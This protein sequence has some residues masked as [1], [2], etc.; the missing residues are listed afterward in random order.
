[1]EI[2][3][4]KRYW[5]LI[6]L[7]GFF[8]VFAISAVSTFLVTLDRDNNTEDATDNVYTGGSILPQGNVIEPETTVT[9]V[10]PTLTIDDAIILHGIY[11]ENK[12]VYEEPSVTAEEEDEELFDEAVIDEAEEEEEAPAPKTE[13]K[14]E[15]AP[16]TEEKKEEVK[17]EEKK[18][19]PKKEEVKV[20]EPKKEEAP[21]AEE[22]KEEA[23]APKVEEKVEE[24]KVEETK[25]EEVKPQLNPD[26]QTSDS[27]L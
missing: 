12:T 23:P 9:R 14:K 7:V 21:K 2:V 15:E 20:E 1:M 6:F 25:K 18:E 22:K 11:G 5:F 8:V 19:E 24:P 27:G 10:T 26:V 4:K 3:M 16:K 13:E 17:T